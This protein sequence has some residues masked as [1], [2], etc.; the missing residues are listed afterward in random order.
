MVKNFNRLWI[1]VALGIAILAISIYFDNPYLNVLIF[2]IGGAIFLT[3]GAWISDTLRQSEEVWM[4]WFATK[5]L[6]VN[7]ADL[8]KDFEDEDDE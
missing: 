7:P 8:D 2:G 3:I 1:L 6:R 4:L 5:I